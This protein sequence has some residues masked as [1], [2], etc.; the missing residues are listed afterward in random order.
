MIWKRAFD[1]QDVGDK[2]KVESNMEAHAITHPEWLGDLHRS[3]ELDCHGEH[4][5]EN[6]E[7]IE[8]LSCWV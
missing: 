5:G 6:D 1:V 3:V 2:P 8:G 7:L 4:G